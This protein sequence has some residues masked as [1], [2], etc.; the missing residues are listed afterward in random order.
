MIDYFI[1][2]LAFLSA[3]TI[4]IVIESKIL[5]ILQKRAEQPIYTEGPSWHLAKK[6]TPTM[7]GVAFTIAI[8]LTLLLLSLVLLYKNGKDDKIS[9]LIIATLFAFGNSLIGVFDDITKLARNKNAGLTPLQKLGLQSIIAIIFLM[10][11]R[12][13]IEDGTSFNLWF[14]KIDL[15]FLYYPFSLILLLGIV[16]CANLTDGVDGLASSVAL[17]IGFIFLTL[18]SIAN[19][20]TKLISLSLIGGTLGFLLFNRHPA[21]IFMGDTGSLFLGALAASLAFTIGNPLIIIFVGAVYVIEGVSVILQV[22]YYKLTK[23]R[24]FKMA[25]LHHHLEKQGV[26]ENQIC[27]V[28]VIIT[29]IASSLVP[30]ILLW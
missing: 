29:L 5:P 13:Y 11:R 28:M 16:N 24:L 14:G 1:Y 30:L 18:S 15:G 20:D 22:C 4:T 17:C 2:F 19:W 10:A 25:P 6:G 21:K 9:S 3:L 12:Y 7:G 23:K 8:T 26:A 27:I